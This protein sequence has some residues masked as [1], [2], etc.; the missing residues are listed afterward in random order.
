[1]AE[2][3]SL[4]IPV[5]RTFFSL[6]PASPASRDIILQLPVPPDCNVITNVALVIFADLVCILGVKV[7]YALQTIGTRL[8]QWVRYDVAFGVVGNFLARMT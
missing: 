8:Y 7:S 5:V 6:N 3:E 1:M 4:R 2:A